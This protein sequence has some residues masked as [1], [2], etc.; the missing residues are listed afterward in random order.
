MKPRFVVF[1]VCALS[2]LAP[3]SIAKVPHWYRHPGTPVTIEWSGFELRAMLPQGWS[4]TASGFAPPADLASSCHVRGV[5]HTD[6]KWDDFLVSSLLAG[7]ERYVLK[8]GGHPAVSSRYVREA[9]TIR[10]IYIDLAALQPDSGAVWTFEGNPTPEGSDCER[11]FVAMIQS[12]RITR[13][14]ATAP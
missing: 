14:T 2:F 8:I 4:A 12:A 9:R 5:F 3:F 6:R 13:A 10:K 1:A 7:D 11:Q